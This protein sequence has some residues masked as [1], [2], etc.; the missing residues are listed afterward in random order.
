LLAPEEV[1]TEREVALAGEPVGDL[2]H[3]LVDAENL[4]DHHDSRPFA[5]GGGR[6][7]AHELSAVFGLDG[8]VLA[9][10][11][12]RLRLG[13]QVIPFIAWDREFSRILYDREWRSSPWRAREP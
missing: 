12:S 3:D 11:R 5:R 7:V 13:R 10:H 4:L 2:A 6:Q 8:D 9:A 1:G